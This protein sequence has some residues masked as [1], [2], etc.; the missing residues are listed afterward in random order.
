MMKNRS[1]RLLKKLKII[2]W[3]HKDSLQQ[4]LVVFKSS[5][6]ILGDGFDGEDVFKDVINYYDVEPNMNYSEVMKEINKQR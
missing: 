2:S 6:F 1:I 5:N 3:H 4:E